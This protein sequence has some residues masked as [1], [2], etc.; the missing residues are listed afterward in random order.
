MKGGHLS[1][2]TI[3]ILQDNLKSSTLQI[4]TENFITS[5]GKTNFP[6]SIPSKMQPQSITTLVILFAY[7]ASVYTNKLP[8]RLKDISYLGEGVSSIRH[9]KSAVYLTSACLSSIQL[10]F[11]A[12]SSL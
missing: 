2:R 7:G 1:P 8:L 6:A 4:S 10:F 3:H 12:V 11:R 5:F 9:A